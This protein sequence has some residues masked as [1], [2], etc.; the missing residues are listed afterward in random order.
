[1]PGREGE[2]NDA[3]RGGRATELLRSHLVNLVAYEDEIN[4]VAHKATIRSLTI[5]NL[6][7]YKMDGVYQTRQ[8]QMGR[9]KCTYEA[10]LNTILQ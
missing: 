3:G 1:M 5:E 2:P 10:Y 9:T 6:L 4:R 7:K 8:D